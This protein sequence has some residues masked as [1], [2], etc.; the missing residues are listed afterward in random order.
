MKKIKILVDARIIGGEAQGSVTYLIGLYQALL[1]QFPNRY[2]IYLAGHH[3]EAMQEQFP[4][5]P[6]E[7]FITLPKQNRL[8]LLTKTY[9]EI[10]AQI[11]PDFAHFQYISPLVKNC[12][13]IVTTHDVLFNDFP[14]EFSIWYKLSRN[15]LFK[16]S[17]VHSDIR[18]TV[19]DYS[20]KAIAQHYRLPA[21]SIAIT[22]NAVRKAF[23]EDYDKKQVQQHIQQ[24]YQ[25]GPYLLYVSRIEPRK[26]QE[27]L[28]QAYL[29]LDLA[30]KGMHLVF[31]GNDT[32]QNSGLAE[33]LQALPPL[34]RKHCHWLKAIDDTD[35][36]AF[37]RAAH[38]FVYPSKA[39]GFGIPPLEAAACQIPTLCSNST[40]MQ[41]FHCLSEH[42]FSPNSLEELKQQLTNILQAPPTAAEL[43]YIADQIQR[44]YSWE[45]SAQVLHREIQQ[46][47]KVKEA[48]LVNM[49]EKSH[50]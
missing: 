38:L 11:K 2:V 17:L 7:Q 5:I 31:I 39:E 16:R 14:E 48:I 19:S 24:K 47:R 45:N 35:L 4:S 30:E 44:Q 42:A 6:S 28:L 10:I 23:F 21:E 9:P 41:D 3:L 40:A 27:L 43:Y 12:K 13:T 15:Y 49:A 46:K 37:Y 1:K 34:Q 50:I 25:I 32:F 20:R 22:P 36:L 26:N 29:D 18:L 33:K 8:L